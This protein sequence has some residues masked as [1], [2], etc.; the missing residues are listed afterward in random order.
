MHVHRLAE[1]SHNPF[2]AEPAS[3]IL[4]R[5]APLT[6]QHLLVLDRHAPAANPVVA[7]S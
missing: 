2:R 1:I 4:V 5:I 6:T 3:L 7:I